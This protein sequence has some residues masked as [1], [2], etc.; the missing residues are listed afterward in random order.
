MSTC[1]DLVN[2]INAVVVDPSLLASI[3]PAT[4]ANL[5]HAAGTTETVIQLGA[6][7]AAVLDLSSAPNVDGKR[8]TVTISGRA[9]QDSGVLLGLYV[10]TS[11]TVASNSKVTNAINLNVPASGLDG[12]FHAEFQIVW[13]S[14]TERV[15]SVA[16]YLDQQSNFNTQDCLLVSG[17]AAQ[18]GLQFILTGK[19]AFDE[20][21][22][23]FT[24]TQ[25]EAR[26]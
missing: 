10:G 19:Y 1:S 12:N 16:T 5:T 21:F 24:I 11:T 17:V 25:F 20:T 15:N 22:N 2:A 8:F 3:D 9:H 6:G 7:G 23:T 14:T 26:F 18:S 13:D 4:I